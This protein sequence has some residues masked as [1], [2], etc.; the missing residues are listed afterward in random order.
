MED[1]KALMGKIIG[2]RSELRVLQDD[3]CRT[4]SY[5]VN[6]FEQGG[7]LLVCGNGGS[8]GDAD[9]IV[10]ELMKGFMKKRRIPQELKEALSKYREGEDISNKIQMALPAISLSS[11]A[12]LIT[13]FSNDIEYDTAFAQQVYGYGRKGDVLIG[14]STSGNSRSVVNAMVTA[15]AIGMVTIAFTGRGGGRLTEL[16]DVTLKAPADSTWEI[17][18]M[19][20]TIYHALCAMVE[21]YFW[22]E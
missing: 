7:K 22:K 14:I 6:S 20:S 13:A 18:D 21:E 9:H 17:Q 8:A 19:H 1:V 3:I 11:H 12:S 15:K 5:I 10:G 16:A 4:F 2:S